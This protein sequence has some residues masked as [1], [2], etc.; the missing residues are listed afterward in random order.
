MWHLL[1]YDGV[2]LETAS[3]VPARIPRQVGSPASM[4]YPD[5]GSSVSNRNLLVRLAIKSAFMVI[6][7]QSRRGR[8][9]RAKGELQP[10]P[11]AGAERALRD[12]VDRNAALAHRR[13]LCPSARAWICTSRFH[14]LELALVPFSPYGGGR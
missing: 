7:P 3:V 2:G 14:L 5:K 6:T 12:K 9:R 13:E 4:T 11:V 1:I 10:G 8:V